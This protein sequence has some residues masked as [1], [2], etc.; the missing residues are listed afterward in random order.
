[1]KRKRP[2][3]CSTLSNRQTRPKS[4]VVP[5][6]IP[7]SLKLKLQTKADKVTKGNLSRLIRHALNKEV[8]TTDQ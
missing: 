2:P 6:R 4:V 1:M 8:C 3:H 7:V 5:V